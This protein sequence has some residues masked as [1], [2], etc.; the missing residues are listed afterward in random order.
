[1]RFARALLAAAV[2]AP[3]AGLGLAVGATAPAWAGNPGPIQFPLTSFG[4]ANP[5]PINCPAGTF[6]VANPGPT[7]SPS[8]VLV[9]PGPSQ[10]PAGID[11]LVNPG[12]TQ[13]PQGQAVSLPLTGANC[14]AGT[15]LLTAE[16]ALVGGPGAPGIPGAAAAAAGSVAS[17]C[18]SGDAAMAALIAALASV[19]T[20]ASGPGNFGF[21][22]RFLEEEGI[23]YFFRHT[24]A[25]H[26][27]VVAAGSPG[28]MYLAGIFSIGPTGTPAGQLL[29][30]APAPASGTF[31]VQWA[32]WSLQASSTPG[33]AIVV[34]AT[35]PFCLG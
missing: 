10:C 32:R 16:A 2:V 31:D 26:R 34:A 23:F 35:C 17:A 29:T 8:F 18:P 5:G 24:D 6:V 4:L 9:S 33:V 3:L 13:S 14:A 25:G 28:V 27:L 15:A 1:M 12:P 21:V 11:V 30:G 7:Q 22:S 19:P 20:V